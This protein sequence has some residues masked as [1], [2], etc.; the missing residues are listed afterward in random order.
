MT[1]RRSK[2]DRMWKPRTFVGGEE[3]KISAARPPEVWCGDCAS[4]MAREPELFERWWESWPSSVTESVDSFL[5]GIEASRRRLFLP[6]MRPKEILAI[7]LRLARDMARRRAEVFDALYEERAFAGESTP[8]DRCL[9]KECAR[10]WES[11]VRTLDEV[12]RRLIRDHDG[13]VRRALNASLEYGG[14]EPEPRSFERASTPEAKPEFPAWLTPEPSRVTPPAGRMPVERASRNI[15][16]R[17]GTVPF[18]ARRRRRVLVGAILALPT[19]Y[20]I[21][22]LLPWSGQ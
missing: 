10:N 2:G 22:Q 12:W 4:R 3:A 17:G 9:V 6:D 14:F 15:I 7:K 1:D 13:P 21:A 8:L 5:A 16:D 20:F 18:R 19:L 11:A